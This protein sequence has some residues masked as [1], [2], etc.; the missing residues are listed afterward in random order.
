MGSPEAERRR[1]TPMSRIVER[2]LD[3][4]LDALEEDAVRM[5]EEEHVFPEKGDCEVRLVFTPLHPD[6]ESMR[7]AQRA[8]A[9]YA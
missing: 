8:M 9:R 2:I 5:S 3:R 1:G 6:E 7:A 4:M